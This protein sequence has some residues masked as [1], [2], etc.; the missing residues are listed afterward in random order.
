MIVAAE[1]TRVRFLQDG[2]S[3]GFEQHQQTKQCSVAGANHS[4]EKWLLLV[5]TTLCGRVDAVMLC[6]LDIVILHVRSHIFGVLL[7]DL[8]SWANC[9]LVVGRLGD[10]RAVTALCIVPLFSSVSLHLKD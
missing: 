10:P 3:T 8:C 5:G 9:C 4:T 7:E 6:Y 1:L 2:E